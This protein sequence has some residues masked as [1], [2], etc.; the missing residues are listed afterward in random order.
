M[1]L[2][3]DQLSEPLRALRRVLVLEHQG[4]REAAVGGD[5]RVVGVELVV[6][7]TRARPAALD[8]Q[9]LVDLRADVFAILLV[10]CPLSRPLEDLV[11]ADRDQRQ[12]A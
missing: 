1:A 8:P 11:V 10:V 7:R 2:E 5:Q 12:S 4:R 9:H 3:A 6:D